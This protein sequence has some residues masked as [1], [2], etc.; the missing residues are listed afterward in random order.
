VTPGLAER[1]R[2]SILVK[3]RSLEQEL[4]DWKALTADAKSGMGRHNTQ[5]RR[6]DTALR[7]MLEP[8]E[9]E[10]A[11]PPAD[12]PDILA[13][14][15]GWEKEILAAHSIWEVF[16]SKL[17]L[18]HNATFM[19]PL[20]ACDDLAWSCYEP[21]MKRFAPGTKGPPLVFLS[22]TWSPFAQSR[23]INFLN[24]I[25]ASPGT[26][27][28]LTA[29]TFQQVL[30]RLPIPLLGLPWY[31]TSHMPGAVLVAHEVGHLVETDFGL[32]DDIVNA[33]RAAAPNNVDVWLGWASEMFADIYGCL[34]MGPYFVGALIDFLAAS[35][36]MIQGED[37]K[38]GKYPTRSLRLEIA[39]QALTEGGHAA[40]VERLRKA[41][42]SVYGAMTRM[43]DFIDDARKVCTQICAGPYRGRAQPPAVPLTTIVAFS[44]PIATVSKVAKVAASGNAANLAGFVEP[45]LLFAAAQWLNENPQERQKAEAY[46]LL[47]MQAVQKHAAE[48]RGAQAV[49]MRTANAER[50]KREEER[51]KEEAAD[52]QVG[53]HL[54]ALLTTLGDPPP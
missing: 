2:T 43:T 6:L 17:V 26:T 44:Q 25:R 54:R 18:R 5:V 19:V 4:D 51:V 47:Q 41:W 48:I 42:E 46:R 11:K 21:A 38:G 22:A 52:R 8:L 20:A 16:R 15:E 24:D 33:I 10:I 9:Q 29:D 31:Q 12:S 14:A 40:E 3:I 13:A 23:D 34:A 37:R 1:R 27:S 28:A 35:V 32:T 50:R 49:D 39:L 45:T 36:T 30:N 53:L 7:S